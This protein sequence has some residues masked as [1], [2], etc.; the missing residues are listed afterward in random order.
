MKWLFRWLNDRRLRRAMADL[1]AMERQ[2]RKANDCRAL[3]KVRRMRR[4]RIHRAL[5][6]AA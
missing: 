3:G 1:D 6:G 5:R 4:E 2:T